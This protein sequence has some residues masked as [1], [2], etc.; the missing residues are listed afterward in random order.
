[1]ATGP[2]FVV[3]VK[4]VVGRFAMLGGHSGLFGYLRSSSGAV[5][6]WRVFES[7]FV[8]PSPAGGTVAGD[9]V[10]VLGRPVH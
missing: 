4:L 7:F 3:A 1:L 9:G 8:T 10:H 6:G 5:I 2:W